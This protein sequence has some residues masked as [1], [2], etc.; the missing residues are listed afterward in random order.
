M[1][2][3]RDW[4]QHLIYKIIGDKIRCTY[5]KVIRDY[6]MLPKDYLVS[7]YGLAWLK[8]KTRINIQK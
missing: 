2:I 1:L 5:Y 3:I 8:I 7:H 4:E 6:N